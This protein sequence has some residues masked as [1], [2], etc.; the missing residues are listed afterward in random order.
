MPMRYYET[1]QRFLSEY[2][3]YERRVLKPTYDEIKTYLAQLE[4]PDYWAKYSP[5]SGSAN[6]S[7][8]RM[9]LIRIKRPEKVV[10]KILRKPDEFPDGLS[11]ESYR[12]MHDT[13]GVRVVVYFSSQLP[14]VDRELRN[15]EPR[16]VEI[17]E[18]DPPE[19]YLSK[20]LIRRLGLTHLSRKEKESGYASIHYT[21]R[22]AKS[23][24]PKED[25]PFF[26]IQIRTLAQELWSELE[27]VLAYRAGGQTNFSA[28]R[29]LEILSRELNAIDEHF[30]LLYE[31]LLHNQQTA[32]YERSDGLS[33]EILPA[34][35][36]EIGVQCSFKDL[37]DMLEI[38]RSRG[39]QTVGDLL[40]L[41]RPRRLETIRNTYLSSTGRVPNSLETIATLA[42]LKGARTV[43]SEIRR[44]NTQI[45]FHR[46]WRSFEKEL[47]PAATILRK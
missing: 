10:D 26:E 18:K 7:P 25:R 9:T 2:E 15:S 30:N 4:T 1:L 37:R 29:R 42:A 34:V 46:S 39:I 6:P 21:V 14:F 17:S 45:E 38:L 23:S 40:E 27:H 28:V 3:A 35:L 47:E 22:L 36:L 19:A 13:I 16:F 24:V 33:L 31:E 20:D 32:Q 43:S 5:E 11:P 12:R 8:I 41:A 44:V